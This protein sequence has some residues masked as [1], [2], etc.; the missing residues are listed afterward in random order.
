MSGYLPNHH[1]FSIPKIPLSTLLLITLFTCGHYVTLSNFREDMGNIQ[2]TVWEAALSFFD[3]TEHRAPDLP[4]CRSLSRRQLPSTYLRKLVRMKR[5]G[6]CRRMLQLSQKGTNTPRIAWSCNLELANQ[7][8]WGAPR[9]FSLCLPV[10]KYISAPFQK[11]C[12][13]TKT[14]KTTF[15]AHPGKLIIF[16]SS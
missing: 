5:M 8:V 11:D 6:K 14:Q 7:S 10:S 12:P 13:S 4:T 9:S 16:S 3:N 1:E 2:P 15:D